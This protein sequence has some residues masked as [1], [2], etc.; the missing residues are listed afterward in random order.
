M[1]PLA[2][3]AEDE[4]PQRDALVALLRESWPE[5]RLRICH[6]GL[7]ALEAL[8]ELSPDLAFLDIR[9]P[10]VDGL[11]VA[12]ALPAGCVIAFTTAYDEHAIAAFE[13]GAIDYVLKP[14]R[15]ERLQQTLQRMR[16]RL[17]S[18]QT[19]ALPPDW[20]PAAEP[21]RWISASVGDSLRLTP[22]D[23]VL[24]FH[25][26]DKYTRVL[27]AAGEALVRVPL[28]DIH[29]RLD[30]SEFAYVHR[31]LIV[32]IRAIDLIRKDELGRWQVRLRGVTGSFPVSQGMV[33][34][35]RDPLG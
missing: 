26:Q 15:R 12:R 14:V 22:L 13:I 4:A 28:K 9:M 35:F 29:P 3:V 32:R 23:E 19:A 33:G 6:D 31:S 16:E 34:R 2:L 30:A 27:T 24:A 21:L 17:R 20:R 25:A 7:A 18:G 1:N 5:L 11:G 8:E 10:G